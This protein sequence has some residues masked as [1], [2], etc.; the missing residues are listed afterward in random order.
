VVRAASRVLGELDWFASNFEDSRI[1]VSE[2]LLFDYVVALIDALA[3]GLDGGA[4][5]DE[6]TAYAEELDDVLAGFFAKAVCE[7]VEG[8]YFFAVDLLDDAVFEVAEVGVDGVGEDGAEDDDLGVV[9]V[10]LVLEKE[11]VEET[12]AKV[13]D[14]VGFEEVAGKGLEEE[15]AVEDVAREA[16]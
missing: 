2:V 11:V 5:E 12:N 6:G 3:G 4:V 16:S 1:L 10:E 9:F 15:A 14:V 7:V 8:S 13:V